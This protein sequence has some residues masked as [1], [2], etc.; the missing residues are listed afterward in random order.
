MNTVQGLKFKGR[1]LQILRPFALYKP[2]EL[3]DLKY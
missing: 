1:M 2:Y 3:A